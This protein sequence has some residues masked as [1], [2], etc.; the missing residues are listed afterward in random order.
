MIQHWNALTFLH[1]RFAPEAVQR[2]LPDGLEVEVRDGGAWVGLVPFLMEVALPRVK[3]VPW[4][5][6]FCETNVRTYV[7]DA[8]GRSG[9]WFFSLDASRLGA[10]V[11]ARTTYRL[12]YFWSSMSV[13]RE[14]SVIRYHCRRRAPGPTGVVSDAVIDIGER[15]QPEQLSTL[16]HFLT[17][18]W[19]LFSVAGTRH[20]FAIAEHQPW[21]LYRARAVD[22]HDE[23]I[24]AAGLP[25]PTDLPLV[26][27]SPG[28]EVKIG[29]P[30]TPPY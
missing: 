27:F 14:G 2:V 7:H 26:H 30:E 15:Y 10:V 24:A 8:S 13:Q 22:V 29:R 28:V 4:A 12:P 23:L 5:S 3:P 1:W 16:E 21:P 6:R 9:I 25:S 11:V 17:A 19:A 20:R 18:R